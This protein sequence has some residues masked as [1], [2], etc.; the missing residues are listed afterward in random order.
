MQRRSRSSSAIP[1]ERTNPMAKRDFQRQR[2]YDAEKIHSHYK[3]PVQE[4][5]SNANGSFTKT[6]DKFTDGTPIM[7][8]HEVRE[9][10][11]KIMRSRW[12]KSRMPYV[13]HLHLKD[14]RGTRWARGYSIGSSLVLNLPRWARYPLIILHEMAHGMLPGKRISPH[15][16]RF[17][18]NFLD[19]IKRWMGREAWFEMKDCYKTQ[20]VKYIRKAQ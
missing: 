12:W 11:E 14:G 16:R 2:V 19:L 9:F 4:W 3:H 20:R 6:N 8:T 17:C 18:A 7:S 10:V 13:H 1:A 15:G 5:T